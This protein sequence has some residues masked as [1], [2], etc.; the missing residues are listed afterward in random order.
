MSDT[1][2]PNATPVPQTPDEEG[3]NSAL[4]Q[5]LG[6][7]VVPL[8]VVLLCVGVFVGFGLI[9]YDSRSVR[10][11]LDDLKDPRPIFSH[12]RKQAAYELSKILSAKPE[13]LQEEVGAQA[14]LR[15]LFASTD[16][17]W[18]RRYLA[19][20]FGHLEDSE[21]L[22][23][24]F[25]AVDGGDEQTRIFALWSL[26][27]IGDRA[28]QPVLL[29]ALSDPDAGIRKTAAFALGGLPADPAVSAALEVQLQ[30]R[31]AD[32]RWNAALSLARLGSDAGR[33]VLEQM[34]ERDLLGQVPEITPQQQEQAM[35]GAIQ[36]LARLGAQDLEPVLDRLA[37]DDPSLKV[38]QA[39]IAARKALGAAS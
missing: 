28:S 37:A 3:D 24:L 9:A 18:V 10:D 38:R 11:Y 17:L 13:A 32:V 39:A 22:P 21:A 25:E 34:L 27:A 6:L 16:D 35:I 14:E 2:E 12:R 1:S 26:G 36:A 8:L 20:V 31:M 7:I 29:E 5:I 23:L 30:D 15:R 19:L 4:R 33:P